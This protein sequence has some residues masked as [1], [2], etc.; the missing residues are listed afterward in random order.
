MA[1]MCNE[2]KIGDNKDLGAPALSKLDS[3]NSVLT[4]TRLEDLW[5][6]YD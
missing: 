4:R 1:G 2:N 3:D 6:R 5:L